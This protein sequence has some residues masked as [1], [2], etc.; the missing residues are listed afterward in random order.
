M[1]NNWCV[2]ERYFKSINNINILIRSRGPRFFGTKD[3]F[4]G[5]C[6]ESIWLNTNLQNYGLVV[7]T[8]KFALPIDLFGVFHY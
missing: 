8:L 6:K 5:P 2:R 1:K 7:Q 4:S 3:T